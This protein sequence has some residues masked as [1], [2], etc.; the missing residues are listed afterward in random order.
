M[1]RERY[2]YP[3]LTAGQVRALD[4]AAE[5]EYGLPLAV[6]MESAG[7]AVA[8]AALRLGGRRVYVAVGH[9]NNG[10]D[11]LVAARLL[12]QAGK[13]VV[14]ALLQPRESLKG[15]AAL[16]AR[17]LAD[18]GGCTAPAGSLDW[19]AADL[20]VDGILGTGIH[21]TAREPAATV[22]AAINEAGAPVLSIDVPSGV[23]ADSG[24]EPE[25]AV[26]A[27]E[28]L[29]LG[30]YKPAL[31]HYPA[32]QWAGR[33]RLANIGIPAS[34]YPRPTAQVLDAEFVRDV[35]PRWPND[36]NK[37]RRGAVLVVAGSRGMLGAACLS[38][39]SATHAGAGLVS[40]A[41]PR[42]LVPVFETKLT[43]QIIRPV[44][45]GG[46]GRFTPEAVDAVLDLMEKADAVVLGPGLSHEE[47]TADFVA[48]L[49]PRVSKPL[50]VDAD[51]LNIVAARG[52][53]LPPHAVM[54]PHPGEMAR[55]LGCDIPEVQRD[56][57]SAARRAAERFGCAVALKGAHTVLAAP[58]EPRVVNLV[59]NP[60]LTTAGTGDV[61]SGVIGALLA[62]G[63]EPFEAALAGVRWHGTMG[64][65]AASER[66]GTLGASELISILP[67]AREA[68]F[69]H[70]K[71][72][73]V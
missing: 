54:T 24:A 13:E 26:R 47:P 27:T 29:A 45:D 35:L 12:H 33:V 5:G 18:A 8:D 9:G 23:D 62:Q 2:G 63:L 58:H 70:S 19:G 64:A 60:V 48:A 3:V 51:G 65:L 25:T 43:D 39:M 53:T 57:L 28:T 40:L 61:L 16:N 37:G 56:R 31:V 7:R 50:L 49:L 52:L 69:E 30:A 14:A 71:T 42:T 68:L 10:G 67:R 15:L 1:K 36:S 55:L 72:D 44:P 20:I 6:L 22:I 59:S 11:A 38:A 41:A 34:L 21:G 66:G 32:A 46:A 73:I 17:R 4:A